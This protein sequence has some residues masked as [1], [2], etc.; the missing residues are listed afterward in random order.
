MGLVTLLGGKVSCSEDSSPSNTIPVLLSWIL[1]CLGSFFFSLARRV[2]SFSG[3]AGISSKIWACS[4][5]KG[6]RERERENRY[7]PNRKN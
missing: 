2:E 1:A 5:E 7:E 6:K 3:N 4:G